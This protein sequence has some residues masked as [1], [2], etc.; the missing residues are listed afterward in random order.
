M[1]CDC[2]K[3]VNEKL[4]AHNGRL[5]TAFQ[6]TGDMGVRMRLLLATEKLDKTKR[7]A[8]P[9]VTASYCPFCGVKATGEP[10]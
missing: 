8:V 7:K 3:S 5:A 9:S 10:K 2:M 4:A 6:I 1:N